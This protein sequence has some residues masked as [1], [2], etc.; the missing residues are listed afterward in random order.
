MGKYKLPSSQANSIDTV[1]ALAKAI[2][3]SRSIST[4]ALEKIENAW[5]R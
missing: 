1:L 5:I 2:A 3:R 4:N